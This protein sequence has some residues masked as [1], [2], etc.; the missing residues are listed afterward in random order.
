MSTPTP[1]PKKSAGKKSKL[2][3][4]IEMQVLNA[5]SGSGG[6]GNGRNKKIIFRIPKLNSAQKKIWSDGVKAAE[7]SL[8][9]S[10]IEHDGILG[11]RTLQRKSKEA[12][13]KHLTG[14]RYF[15]FLIGDFESMLILLDKAPVG[16]LPSCRVATVQLF[17]K[18]KI[19]PK[20]SIL[21]GDNDEPIIDYE[22]KEIECV[23]SWNAPDNMRQFSSALTLVH[24]SRGQACAYT[25][26][27][28][29]C[30]SGAEVA[31]SENLHTF[32]G[33]ESH[34]PNRKIS[35]QGDPMTDQRLLDYMKSIFVEK[36]A[37]VQK[38][39]SPITPFELLQVR[40]Y[41]CST[42]SLWDF[43]IYVMI[44]LGVKLFLRSD[45]LCSITVEQFLGDFAIVS[46]DY[47]YLEGIAVVIQG[48]SDKIP[49]TLMLWS[50]HH[51]P[52]YCPIRHLLFWLK[53]SGIKSG[54]IFPSYEFLMA[55]MQSKDWN[56]HVPTPEEK[57]EDQIEKCISYSTFQNRVS[58]V[59][60]S[61]LCRHGPWGTHTIRKTAYL[62]AIWGKGNF[63]EIKKGARHTSLKNS[64]KYSADAGTL[65]AI[66]KA[67]KE[68][69]KTFPEWRPIFLKELQIA[70]SINMS[71]R[72]FKSL[73]Y[74]AEMLFKMLKVP[75]KCSIL[76]SIGFISEAV[77]KISSIFEKFGQ[78]I[79][80]VRETNPEEAAKIE[81]LFTQMASVQRNNEVLSA[82]VIEDNL[83]DFEFEESL[84]GLSACDVPIEPIETTVEHSEPVSLNV[85]D[86]A[87]RTQLAHPTPV[88]AAI[89]IPTHRPLIIQQQKFHSLPLIHSRP[90]SLT[91]TSK[92]SRIFGSKSLKPQRDELNCA[93]SDLEKLKMC[94]LMFET[95]QKEG[96]I[97]E[98]D[99]ASRCFFNSS[100]V[101]IMNCFK[102]HCD[103]DVV[104]FFGKHP[105]LRKISKFKCICTDD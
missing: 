49:V 79:E 24:I 103:S 4:S 55:D 56:F 85:S 27:C 43:M 33:C 36:S 6:S 39:D 68:S 59:F 45:E 37:Y 62:F 29:D 9:A 64:E 72:R 100:L 19:F 102:K 31:G 70:Q 12:Y 67:S 2:L 22:G 47:A 23:G 75:K 52:L 3:Q 26:A 78:S 48:K 1:L 95:V 34:H 76:D 54:C 8:K 46:G 94:S 92:K 50:D 61:L 35:R 99:N 89:S 20:G 7:K 11:T 38:G 98:F 17:I 18:W 86:S 13:M 65:L 42:N 15:C 91:S 81:I 25:E 51:F 21:T 87:S 105:A 10:Q 5:N 104:Q 96:G 90:A 40:T 58:K 63:E 88:I 82:N 32:F 14:L 71:S 74:S 28:L 84:E 57:S 73:S 101:P 66:Y 30:L 60:R 93:A 16:R 41:L 77:P 44:L 83:E 69:F 53:L 80:K 97:G